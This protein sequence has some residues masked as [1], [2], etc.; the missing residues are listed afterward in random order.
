MKI[1]EG[2]EQDG[3]VIGNTYDKYSTRNPIERRLMEGYI[4]TLSAFVR[5]VQSGVNSRSWLRGRI[6]G[7]TV[8]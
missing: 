8:G 5:I 1:S 4:S 3:V 2:Q 7:N 6:L